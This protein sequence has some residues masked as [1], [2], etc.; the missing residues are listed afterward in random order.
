MFEL[1]YG[2]A[3][4]ATLVIFCIA[5]L[6]GAAAVS[7]SPESGKAL[8]EVMREQIVGDVLGGDP[9]ILAAKIFL[10]NLQASILLFLGGASFGLLTLFILL[11]NGVVIGG[12]LELVREQQGFLFV[13]AAILPHG[14]FEVPSFIIAGSLG[15]MLA[16]ALYREW[17]FGEDA[18]MHALGLGRKFVTIVVPLLAVASMIEAFITPEIINFVI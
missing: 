11:V 18:A 15:L 13:A 8:L 2:R 17:F 3:I 1:T 12:V 9:L 16:H 10:N 4:A 5:A 7:I 14:L 6:L